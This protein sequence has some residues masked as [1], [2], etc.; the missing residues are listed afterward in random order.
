MIGAFAASFC[1]SIRLAPSS[2]ACTTVRYFR[3][4]ATRR[5]GRGRHRQLVREARGARG[6]GH[7]RPLVGALAL[8]ELNAVA[9]PARRPVSGVDP[10]PPPPESRLALGPHSGACRDEHPSHA[11]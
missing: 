8:A 4:R 10:P 2:I 9:I 5:P 1:V 7:D 6:A 3:L 11:L